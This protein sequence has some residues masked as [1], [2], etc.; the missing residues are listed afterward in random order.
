MRE[1]GR[2][3]GVQRT[4]AAYVLGHITLEYLPSQK[5]LG[6]TTSEWNE[7]STEPRATV[8]KPSGALV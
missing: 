5:A 3:K 6:D 7:L 4:L 8:E 2:L 1:I